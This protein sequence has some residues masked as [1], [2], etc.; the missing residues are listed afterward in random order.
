[1]MA[2]AK[3]IDPRVAR[4]E[5]QTDLTTE[6]LPSIAG[7]ISWMFGLMSI[8]L[9]F[10]PPTAIITG[11]LAIIF[12]H[13]AKFKI[14]RRLE[15]GGEGAATGGLLMGYLCFFAALALLP[16]IR[17]QATLTEGIANSFRGVAVAASGSTFEQAERSFLD[18]S[19]AA[20]GNNKESREIA[21]ELANLLNEKRNEIFGG[22]NGLKIQTLCQ[23]NEKGICVVALVPDFA[24]FDEDARN[25][26]LNLIWKESQRLAFG[27]LSPGNDFAVAVRDRIQYHSM[28]FGRATLSPDRIAQPDSSFVDVT[29]LDSYFD[30]SENEEPEKGENDE[31]RE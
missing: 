10:V 29:M 21:N 31:E 30:S 7:G 23:A 27:K 4:Q 20:T 28:E 16:S 12:G 24:D 6:T 22:P 19:A 17:M 25:A 3:R 8:P 1:M 2:N 14:N 9:L 15:L 5:A 18:S 26:M 11:L 13:V